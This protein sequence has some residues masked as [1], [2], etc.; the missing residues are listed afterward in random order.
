MITQSDNLYFEMSGHNCIGAIIGICPLITD[1]QT[2][3]NHIGVTM[4]LLL[5]AA[6][7]RAEP[8]IS[9]SKVNMFSRESID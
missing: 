1:T 6:F 8:L 7:S 4:G 9:R 3:V 5:F 2:I